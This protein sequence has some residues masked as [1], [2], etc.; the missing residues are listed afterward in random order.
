LPLLFLSIALSSAS[1]RLGNV[2]LYYSLTGAEYYSIDETK[3]RMLDLVSEYFVD[4]KSTSTLSIVNFTQI[5]TESCSLTM[6]EESAYTA[7]WNAKEWASDAEISVYANSVVSCYSSAFKDL[8]IDGIAIPGAK[9]SDGKLN[10]AG[11]FLPSILR[12][13]MLGLQV[14]NGV[15]DTADGQ[16]VYG[17]FLF[18][19]AI[20][21]CSFADSIVASGCYEVTYS[22]E[23]DSLSNYTVNYHVNEWPIWLKTSCSN[24]TI[25]IQVEIPPT[26]S[27]YPEYSPSSSTSSSS[28]TSTS[29]SAWTTNSYPQL[30]WVAQLTQCVSGTSCEYINVVPG[31]R[32]QHSAITYKSWN[33]EE[34]VKSSSRIC[35]MSPQLTDNISCTTTCLTDLSCLGVTS[36]QYFNDGPDAYYWTTTTFD[37]DDGYSQAY[38][39]AHSSSCPG[40][41]CGSRKFCYRTRDHQGSVVPFD[42]SY[43][44]IFGGKS[45]QTEIIEGM[46]LLEYCQTLFGLDLAN[47]E[48]KNC[49]EFESDE[50]WRYDIT[51]DKWEYIKPIAASDAD[52]VPV[53]RHGH[54][55]VYHE[56]AASADSELVKRK[57]MYMFGGRSK[58]CDNSI[59]SD[60]WRFE[61]PW[62]AQAYWSL[63]DM[64]AGQWV[65]LSS[66]EEYG[67]RHKHSMI[68]LGGNLYV[69]GG[70]KYDSTSTESD[71]AYVSDL[72]IYD[73][74]SNTWNKVSA[75]GYRY[76]TR[77]VV[78]Y[79]GQVRLDRLANFTTFDESDPT[80]YQL[81]IT[82][83][84]DD[85]VTSNPAQVPAERGS[86]VLLKVDDSTAVLFSGFRAMEFSDYDASKQ[87]YFNDLW[88]ISNTD[89]TWRQSFAKN[90]SYG[91]SYRRGAAGVLVNV[92]GVQ[93]LLVFGGSFDEAVLSDFW[94]YNIGDRSRQDREWVSLSWDDMVEDSVY[95]TMTYVDGKIYVFGGLYWPNIIY[96]KNDFENYSS[97]RCYRKARELTR[98][99]GLTLAAAKQRIA[100][101]C[102]VSQTFCCIPQVDTAT[103]LSELRAVCEQ[104]CSGTAG[105]T[106]GHAIMYRTGMA[107]FDPTSCP[108]DCSGNGSCVLGFCVC[109][110]GWSGPSCS[111]S[112]CPGSITIRG[113]NDLQTVSTVCS[114]H[115]ICN[116]SQG[117]CECFDGW[118][119]FDCSVKSCVSQCSNLGSEIKGDCY[120]DFPVG[121]CVC[122]GA[123]YGQYC[124]NIACLN[125]CSG[126]GTCGSEGTCT[127]D[128]SFY[129][130]DCS[131]YVPA[132]FAAAS[133]KVTL[134]I[135]GYLL[136]VLL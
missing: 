89:Y 69:Y 97:A 6:T 124:E 39:D 80:V 112:V 110:P 51:D 96:N 54:A 128:D 34:D 16:Y 63:S 107:V 1:D 102:N 37:T 106:E 57:Y 24:T 116:S 134:L 111:V 12:F 64:S 85:V 67:G 98:I 101:T 59:C 10:L 104:E 36:A 131:L 27:W 84:S 58:L 86:A 53:G 31:P 60:L 4:S 47:S 81:G 45:K 72:L 108:L 70:V 120:V 118:T 133:S 123:Y 90:D 74:A 113:K 117:V 71:M 50:L 76:F 14:V 25:G 61:I 22:V 103:S 79:A 38:F 105:S 29:D 9:I 119:E 7:Y 30:S 49:Y 3:E 115:G 126:H 82:G 32:Y 5:S 91:P 83:Y 11:F 73:L 21:A 28:S 121:H 41:C 17:S 20:S 94:V 42:H 100:E 129:G 13:L 18:T 52:G 62:A 136:V 114:N 75:A 125:D 88:N 19:R 92:T 55:A 44:L 99:A 65:K 56:V 135:L 46:D 109:Q 8:Y 122:S 127:C 26:I 78:D 23:S 40:D 68:E 132:S 77:T 87:Y 15:T 35:T 93:Q 2:T 33:F 95:H 43:I 48:Q 66:C 130:E